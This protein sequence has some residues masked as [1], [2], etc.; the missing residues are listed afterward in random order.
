[1][2]KVLQ[3]LDN[4]EE[5]I[6]FVLLASM[7]LIIGLQVI[8]RFVFHSSLSWS[9]EIAR[10]ILV[11]A[12][13]IGGSLGVKKGAHIGV[14]AFTLVLPA[15]GK[16]IVTYVASACCI[17][18]CLIIFKEGLAIILK[19]ITNHQVSPAM[20]LPMWIPYAALPVGSIL[21]AVRFIQSLMKAR[22]N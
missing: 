22:K 8:S 21:M 17:V 18:F 9:E 15:K 20:Q 7:T 5:Y 4:L 16:K 3:V 6:I 2:K 13:F 19:Q 14:E 11:W 1:M 10:Y 12:T